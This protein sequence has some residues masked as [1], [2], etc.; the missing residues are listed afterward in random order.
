MRNT[1]NKKPK[2]I[3]TGSPAASYLEIQFANRNRQYGAYELRKNYPVRIKVALC[4]ITAISIAAY[5]Y[6]CFVAEP[7][8]RGIITYSPLDTL[9][10]VHKVSELIIAA[11]MAAKLATA[12]T[13]APL[14][15]VPDHK[16]LA[17]DNDILKANATTAT[18][19]GAGAGAGGSSGGV[20]N[21]AANGIP[22][23]DTMPSLRPEQ[24][25]QP[26][27]S[28]PKPPAEEHAVADADPSFPG[29]FKALE[30]YLQRQLE[31]PEAAQGQ[32]GRVVVEFTIDEA[33]KLSKIQLLN[34]IHPALAAEAIR[35][36]KLMPRWKPGT[37]QGRA[38]ES[39]WQI[40]ITF[41]EQL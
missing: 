36:I 27:P 34:Q 29:G 15:V 10:D 14:T 26:K 23:T 22:G 6:V 18:S 16:K 25:S 17:G 7:A 31:F 21:G 35:I 40:P 41:N 20:P 37:H 8:P 11:P 3:S 13:D 1:M 9:R 19:A 24:P 39:K 30:N 4:V 2:K 32:T 12:A 33:G 5:G 28:I 38:V